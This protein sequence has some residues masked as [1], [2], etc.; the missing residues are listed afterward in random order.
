M[1]EFKVDYLSL[2]EAGWEEI[3]I[4]EGV[5][6][7]C[8]ERKLCKIMVKEFENGLRLILYICEDCFLDDTDRHYPFKGGE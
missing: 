3:D 1:S 7:F 6:S 4:Q 5:C 8:G 2:I